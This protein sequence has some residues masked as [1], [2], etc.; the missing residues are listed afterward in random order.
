MIAQ[1]LRP[2]LGTLIAAVTRG[3]L[4]SGRRGDAA[5]SVSGGLVPPPKRCWSRRSTLRPE[6][7]RS[8]CSPAL[9]L[10]DLL[11]EEEEE[12]DARRPTR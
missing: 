2:R 10:L 3:V 5:R 1:V 4:R 9:I 12:D 7:K 6:R 11:E 8:N